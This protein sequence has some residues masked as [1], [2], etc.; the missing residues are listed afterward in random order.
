MFRVVVARNVGHWALRVTN[1]DG[2]ILL[3]EDGAVFSPKWRALG[4][5]DSDGSLFPP[6]ENPGPGRL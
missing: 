5:L 1:G 4:I 3:V 2:Q 6:A